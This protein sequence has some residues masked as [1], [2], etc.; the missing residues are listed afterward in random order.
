MYE[1]LYEIAE[2]DKLDFVKADYHAFISQDNGEKYFLKR[3]NFV[4]KTIYDKVICPRQ[5]IEVATGDWY[6]CQGI[7]RTDFIRENKIC[8]SETKGAAF[9]DIGF[10]YFAI[11]TAKRAEY[12]KDSFYR[13]RIDRM[14]SSSNSG[15]GI[16]Y[17]Y[18]EF[19]RLTQMVENSDKFDA[20]DYRVLYIRMIKSFLTSYGDMS[21]EFV[22]IKDDEREKYY[23]W[24][25]NKMNEAIG[26][27]VVT[28]EDVPQSMWRGL[29]ALLESEKKAKEKQVERESNFVNWLKENA[30][31]KISVFGGG[32]YGYMAHAMMKKNGFINDYFIDNNKDLWG[33]TLDGVIV[34]G[35][36]KILEN[37]DAVAVVIANALYADAIK[38][39]ILSYKVPKERIFVFGGFNEDD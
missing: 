23:L 4:D 5:V 20:D 6:N 25:K 36:E 14:E 31:M 16:K 19:Y 13:Y 38:K 3:E 21:P 39:Q 9:Q 30:D 33:K 34:T 18:D 27:G 15:R 22:K 7:Y 26:N 35:P 10:L 32:N 28:E 1:K 24:F 17:S 11:V 37:K 12:I 8:F 29:I 2:R